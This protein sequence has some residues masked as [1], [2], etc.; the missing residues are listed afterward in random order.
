MWVFP[1][2]CLHPRC[3]ACAV[4]PFPRIPP[5][6]S[7]PR[8]PP[9][10]RL[11]E[12]THRARGALEGQFA[13]VTSDNLGALMA[14]PCTPLQPH[15]CTGLTLPMFAARRGR[16][17][18]LEFLLPSVPQEDL[19]ARCRSGGLTLLMY[20]CSPWG[21]PGGPD[22]APEGA[23]AA[24]AAAVL[25]RRPLP[26]VLNAQ[27]GD[28][29]RRDTALHMACRAGYASVVRLL[30]DAPGIQ[31]AVL[32]AEGLTAFDVATPHAQQVCA[33][34]RAWC[35]VRLGAVRCS[36]AWLVAPYG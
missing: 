14:G 17:A 7:L 18:I 16:A 26:P 1:P 31:P 23:K 2:P 3:A 9:T 19:A 36:V 8:A 15:P 25:A 20:A 5:C 4:L 29:A 27:A 6:W 10:P 13:L 32:N 11:Q 35:G 12:A 28:A 24:C 33:V 30:L 21:S 34:R 22:T